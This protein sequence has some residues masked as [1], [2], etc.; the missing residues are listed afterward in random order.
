MTDL[1][2][3]VKKQF[4]DHFAHDHE[5]HELHR[6]ADDGGPVPT[7]IHVN[8]PDEY[9]IQ[10]QPRQPP[11][12]LV[13]GIVAAK[14]H[15]SLDPNGDKYAILL[16]SDADGRQVVLHVPHAVAAMASIDLKDIVREI[17]S[18]KANAQIS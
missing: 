2:A 9:D 18:E 1:M 8:V 4:E 13:K 16:V 15:S 3:Q 17:S 7:K 5:D 12:Y 14:G 10:Y 11:V 6:F